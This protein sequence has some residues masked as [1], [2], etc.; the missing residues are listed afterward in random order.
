MQ[1]YACFAENVD[2]LEVKIKLCQI[3]SPN[4]IEFLSFLLLPNLNDEKED[5]EPAPRRTCDIKK[6]QNPGLGDL[7]DVEIQGIISAR[8]C[9]KLC[10]S[11]FLSPNTLWI[12]KI[13]GG[14]RL[15]S[16]WWVMLD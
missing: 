15:E 13:M 2:R 10:I 5:K 14:E 3:K 9:T 4:S 8:I 16:L 11:G 7:L 1:L 6:Q 12:V